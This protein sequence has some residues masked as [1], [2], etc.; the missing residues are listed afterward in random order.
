MI[1]N[2]IYTQTEEAEYQYASNTYK[3][4]LTTKRISG[5]IDDKDSVVQAANKILNTE[6]YAYEIYSA[7][8]GTEIESLIS[9][10][11][12][13][14]NSVLEQ[15]IKDA[16]RVDDRIINIKNFTISNVDSDSI[17]AEF[18]IETTYGEIPF[19]IEVKIW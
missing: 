7:D 9:K 19:N 3:L 16:L 18:Y 15:R 13:F 8:Y 11:K 14:V 4:D 2:T 6:R 5:K 1:P 12:D 10:N 17:Y